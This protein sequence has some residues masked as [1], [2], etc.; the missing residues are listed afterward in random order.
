MV[1][2]KQSNEY[3]HSKAYLL[4]KQLINGKVN[5]SKYGN[6]KLFFHII[7]CLEKY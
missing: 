3:K 1:I 5:E 7:E 2:K 4:E 6:T